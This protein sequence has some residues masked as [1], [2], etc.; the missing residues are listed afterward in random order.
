LVADCGGNVD[1][2]EEDDD[3]ENAIE[4]KLLLTKLLGI[5]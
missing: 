4:K 3:C 5:R 1:S 2:G